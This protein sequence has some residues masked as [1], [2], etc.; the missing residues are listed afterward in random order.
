MGLYPD[1][2]H[3]CTYD[4]RGTLLATGTAKPVGKRGW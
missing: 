2:L 1:A 4:V 3:I